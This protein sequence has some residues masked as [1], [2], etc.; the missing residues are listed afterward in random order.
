MR[1]HAFRR[2]QAPSLIDAIWGRNCAEPLNPSFLRWAVADD[3]FRKL[4]P[5]NVSIDTHYGP[6][7]EL[8]EGN[9]SQG[10]KSDFAVGLGSANAFGLVPLSEPRV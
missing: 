1:A 8:A 6:R 3:Q 2:L 5:L 10:L 7:L 4:G 9:Q